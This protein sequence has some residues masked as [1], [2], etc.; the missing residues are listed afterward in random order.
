MVMFCIE[1]K[2][3]VE[4]GVHDRTFGAIFIEIHA[5]PLFWIPDYSR[6]K[7]RSFESNFKSYDAKNQSKSS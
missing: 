2:V 1:S 6:L 7:F 4:A 3:C 5:Q